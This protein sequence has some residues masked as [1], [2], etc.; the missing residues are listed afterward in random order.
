MQVF[1]TCGSDSKKNFLLDQFSDLRG[2]HIG[3]SHSTS[4]EGLVQSRTQGLGVHLVLN[5]LTGDKLKVRSTDQ[6]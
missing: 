2:D 6:E 5:S 3:D 4:F 1:A